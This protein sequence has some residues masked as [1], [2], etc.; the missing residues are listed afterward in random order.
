MFVNHKKQSIPE[1]MDIKG[2]YL[3][4]NKTKNVKVTLS[5]D[6]ASIGAKLTFWHQFSML[7]KFDNFI[8]IFKQEQKQERTLEI[9]VENM[10]RVNFMKII[11]TQ[12]KGIVLSLIF[13]SFF[14]FSF[15]IFIVIFFKLQEFLV[16]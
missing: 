13:K 16:K 8:A 9:L 15:S 2:Q 1:V 10:G 3:N 12:R 14:L 4:V 6:Q 11:N 5:S 7:W